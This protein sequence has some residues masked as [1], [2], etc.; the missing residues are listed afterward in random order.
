M[1]L[2]LQRLVLGGLQGGLAARQ[3][4]SL[5]QP[6]GAR[7]LANVPQMPLVE[8]TQ[9]LHVE[10]VSESVAA[11]REVLVEE[12]RRGVASFGEGPGRGG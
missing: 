1:P 3:Q 7:A 10:L 5:K 6:V 4:R 12:R 11:A 8:L 2:R 9:I